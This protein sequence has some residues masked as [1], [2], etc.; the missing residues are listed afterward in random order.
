MVDRVI[1]TVYRANYLSALKALS[2]SG[3]PEPLIRMLDYAQEWTRASIGA[4]SRKPGA[5][6]T[7][8]TPF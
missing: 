7:N 2:H 5:N 1:P 3:L 8:A 6:S 4:R